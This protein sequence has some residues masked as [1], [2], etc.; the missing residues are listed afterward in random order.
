MQTKLPEGIRVL[1]V[2]GFGPVVADRD[3]SDKLYR[4]VLALPLRHEDG[5][6]GYWHSQCIEGVKHFA[7]WPLDKAAL[8]CFGKPAWPANLPVP[9][10]W[11]ELDV[12]DIV[13]ATRILEQGGYAL[14]TRL[15]EEPWGQTVTRFL[16]PEGILMALTHTPFLRE[17]A[18]VEETA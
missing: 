5:Y 17:A 4:K 3:K 12:E 11:L 7:L 9:Q 14:L 10:A 16:S 1:F 15:K 18:S 6:E 13:A 2:A 8:S